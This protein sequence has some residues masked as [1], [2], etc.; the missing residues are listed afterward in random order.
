MWLYLNN[1]HISIVETPSWEGNR[2]FDEEGLTYL[3]VR[4]RSKEDLIAFTGV[5]GGEVDITPDRDYLAR[6]FL[7][8]D[9]VSE[10]VSEAVQSINYS[11]FKGSIPASDG[12]RSL[13]YNNVWS[14]G[15]SHNS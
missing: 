9:Q 6:V 4:A 8:R 3:S 15:L 12:R 7:P 5:E 13:W 14:E 11:N 10:L 2:Q 1:S